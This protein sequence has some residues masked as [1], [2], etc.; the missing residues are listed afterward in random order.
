MKS[1][2]VELESLF[3][4]RMKAFEGQL[5][6]K[7]E[8]AHQRSRSKSKPER[9]NWTQESKSLMTNSEPE[10]T[11]WMKDFD[12][13]ETS[14]K[15]SRRRWTKECDYLMTN[16]QRCSALPLLIFR[17]SNLQQRVIVESSQSSSESSNVRIP[18]FEEV[19]AENN[20]CPSPLS[21]ISVQFKQVEIRWTKLTAKRTIVSTSL[22]KGIKANGRGPTESAPG[23]IRCRTTH[24]SRLSDLDW[25][26]F[27]LKN[28]LSN[29]LL[30]LS[31]SRTGRVG[32][33]EDGLSDVRRL[34]VIL[35]GLGFLLTL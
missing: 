20:E 18:P 35:L 5:Q 29:R 13:W 1:L 32:E 17:R 23:T 10:K 14:L 7:V 6:A 31:S 12:F 8:V 3:S 2:R 19:I 33:V 25:Q 34:K 30:A 16:S 22:A 26:E 27:L 21:D 9:L 4:E 24:S 11:I 28:P 15:P